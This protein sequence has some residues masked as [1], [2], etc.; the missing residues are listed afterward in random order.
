[1]TTLSG[2][3]RLLAVLAVAALA[4][5]AVAG[6]SSDAGPDRSAPTTTTTDPGTTG[7]AT[8]TTTPGPTGAPLA[9]YADY[10]TKEYGDPAHWVCRPD[11]TDICD[12]NLDTTV[13]A[14]DGS[15]TVERFRAD[16]DAPVDCFYVYPTISRDQTAY[17]DWDASPDEEGFVTRQQAARL[18]SVCRVFAPVY[19][20]RTLAG[21]VSNMA[22]GD[23]PAGPVADPVADVTDA[24]RTYMARDNHGR[25]VVLIGHSQGAGMLNALIKSEI[26]P[27]DDVR[28]LLVGAYLAGGS[29]A[30]PPGQ[31]VGGDFT[32]VP[33]CTADDE[34]GCVITWASFEA[35]APP[36]P[37]SFFG[38]VRGDGGGEAGCVNPAGFTGDPVLHAYLPA[39]RGVSILGGDDTAPD[40]SWLA[41][42]SA[43]VTTPFVSLP[44]LIHGTCATTNGSHYLSISV[45]PGPGDRRVTDLGGRLTPEWG[46]HLLD[47]NLVMGDVVD[48]VTGQIAAWK[49]G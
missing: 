29:V 10:E 6:C 34:A 36:P 17:S 20:Q 13:V 14:A 33:L 11:T 31:V 25:G 12:E 44:G 28:R 7:G 21:L 42:G 4:P 39:N 18:G 16:P 23:A 30:V 45:T 8:T 24:F 47:V 32:H 2:A 27:H 1:M 19:R 43:P 49:A 22:G 48:R 26:D 35:T 40:R 37:N 46:L 15:Q 9:R 5:L 3:R 41:D 38:K